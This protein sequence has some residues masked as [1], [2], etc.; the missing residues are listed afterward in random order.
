VGQK[1]GRSCKEITSLST[2]GS[3]GNN[4]NYHSQFNWFLFNVN[5]GLTVIATYDLDM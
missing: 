5:I 4:N 2:Q 1:G 3:K